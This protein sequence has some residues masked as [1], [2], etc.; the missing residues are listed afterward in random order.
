MQH[1]TGIQSQGVQAMM[2]HYINNEQEDGR[3]W[4][5]SILDDRTAH[6]LYLWPFQ[7]AVHAG[8]VSAMCSYNGIN[9]TY[10]CANPTSLGKWLHE[11]LNFQ[12]YVL[13]D[14]AAIYEGIEIDAANAGC[15][16]VIGFAQPQYGAAATSY[17]CKFP[18]GNRELTP[19]PWGVNSTL[20]AAVANGSVSEARL[21]DM[22]TR[23]VAAWYQVGQDK[24]FP[25]LNTNANVLKQSTNALIRE[26]GAKSAVLL[27]N[28]GVLPL[29]NIS[30]LYVFGNAATVN[31]EG[32]PLPVGFSF[33]ID[34]DQGTYAGGQ[35]S[36]YANLPYLITPFEALQARA[37]QSASQVFGYFNNFNHTNQATYA[38]AAQA[39][40]APCI[41]DVRQQCS[42][43]YDRRNLSASWE[44]DE[45]ILAVAAQCANTV[46][47]YASC[48][49]F[50]GT[51]WANHENVTAIINSGG[52]GQESGNALVDVL[53]GDVNP[54]AR[55]PYTIGNL[56]SDYPAEQVAASLVAPN[57]SF[58]VSC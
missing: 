39:L 55:L 26:L 2:R 14:Y 33:A 31:L 21:T 9:G 36:S 47:I 43:G 19:V 17:T 44:G 29:R 51:A 15:D 4:V 1:V 23:I 3:T 27:K 40:G 37:R 25:A 24:K 13:S 20:S 52:G 32:F 8:V 46:V 49:P 58:V 53:Y 30:D 10:S 57:T 48:G 6:E 42:E 7:D 12:G 50:N 45:T 5:N 54:S 34:D 35:G 28:T 18:V 38:A 41:V 56:R 22:A 11:E 16:T